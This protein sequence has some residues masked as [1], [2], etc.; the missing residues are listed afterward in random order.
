MSDLDQMS[1]FSARGR[2]DQVA[3]SELLGVAVARTSD[4]PTSAAAEDH[5]NAT[6]VRA[7]QAQAV[8]EWVRCRPGLTSRELAFASCYDGPGHEMD[9][10]VFARRLPD[11]ETLGRVRK[12][13]AR[14]CTISGRRAVT[15][16]VIE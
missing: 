3:A 16:E 13:A 4:P 15:W 7:Q 14:T 10:Y 9:R 2:R 5:V 11:L 8:L 1:L 6:G 12:A